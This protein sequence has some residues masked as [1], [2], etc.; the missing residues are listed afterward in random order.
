MGNSGGH[1]TPPEVEKMRGVKEPSS[2]SQTLCSHISYVS[3]FLACGAAEGTVSGEAQMHLL[4]RWIGC[5]LYP[6]GE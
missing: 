2:T 5:Q 6:C 4:G 3:H 1:A